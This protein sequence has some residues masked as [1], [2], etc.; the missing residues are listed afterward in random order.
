MYYFAAKDIIRLLVGAAR[1]RAGLGALVSQG[2]TMRFSNTLRVSPDFNV[3]LF[4]ETYP[5]NDPDVTTIQTLR[6]GKQPFRVVGS[7]KLT[8]VKDLLEIGKVQFVP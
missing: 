7:L 5:G 2:R 3:P 4:H 1:S 8:Q 6:S